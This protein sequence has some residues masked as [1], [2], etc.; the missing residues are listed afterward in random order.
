MVEAIQRLPEGLAIKTRKRKATA[1][2]DK[3]EVAAVIDDPVR[4]SNVARA[5]DRLLTMMMVQTTSPHFKRSK[6]SSKPLH[7]SPLP[8]KSFKLPKAL[9][10]PDSPT[11]AVS[12]SRVKRSNR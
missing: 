7:A 1:K 2:E 12:G 5:Q 4:P 11:K 9:V 6:S 10:V 3:E 8:S